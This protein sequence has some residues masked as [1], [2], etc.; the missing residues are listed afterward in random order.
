MRDQREME[1]LMKSGLIIPGGTS[2]RSL[3]PEGDEYHA[4][5]RFTLRDLIRESNKIEGIFRDP[6]DEE[7][8]A[9]RAFLELST[10]TI[11]ALEA[12]VAVYQ[13]GARLR[14]KV[15]LNVRVGR[16]LPP[17]GSP[18]IRKALQDLLDRIETKELTPFAAHMEYETLHPFTDGNGRSGRILW[19]WMMPDA[20]LGFMHH[21][22]YQSL[23]EGRK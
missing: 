9:A 1:M 12:F 4:P 17:A 22:Y 13:P 19:L 5:E 20:S 11:A 10:I 3:N 7:V 16:H 23:Q 8:A 21:W 2:R 18:K 14:D 6:T 15:G